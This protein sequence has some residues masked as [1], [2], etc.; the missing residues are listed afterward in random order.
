MRMLGTFDISRGVLDGSDDPGNFF[1]K[2]QN[3]VSILSLLNLLSLK[4][5]KEDAS[6]ASSNP[7]PMLVAF[8]MLSGLISIFFWKLM[9]G[10]HQVQGFQDEPDVEPVLHEGIGSS[11]SVEAGPTLPAL[12]VP[13]PS[14]PNR[15]LTA[16]NYVAWLLENAAEGVMKQLRMTGAGCMKNGWQSRMGLRAALQSP[17][18]TFR[19]SPRRTLGGMIDISDDEASNHWSHKFGRCPTC[20]GVF[21]FLASWIKFEHR[22]QHKCWYG[23]QCLVTRCSISASAPFRP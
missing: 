4:G 16:E 14:R 22:V 23:C 7:S 11:A 5:C 19:T 15:A 1:R 2:K 18:E 10:G 3:L 17:H 6:P 21:P 12:P 20:I 13:L 9:R 8:T